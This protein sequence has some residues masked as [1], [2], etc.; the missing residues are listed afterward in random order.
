MVFW[1]GERV[2]RGV[3][4]CSFAA[5]AAAAA[6]PAAGAEECIFDFFLGIQNPKS[7]KLVILLFWEFY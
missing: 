4:S 2:W 1:A 5:A 3:E 6:A 7:R